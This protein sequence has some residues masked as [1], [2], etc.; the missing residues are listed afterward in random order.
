MNV[1]IPASRA[2]GPRSTPRWVFVLLA[3]LAFVLLF[4]RSMSRFFDLDEHQ[5]VVPP[6]L[7]GQE[8]LLPYR[9]YPYFHM[10]GLVYL[11]APLL[12]WAPDKL[13]AARL[14]SVVCGF[15]TL[16]LLFRVGWR[17]LR[18]LP[19]STRW[20][21][22]GGVVLTFSCSRLFTYTSGWAWNHD[23][24]VL[25]AL[26]AFLVHL[27]G[28]RLARLRCFAAAG[29]LAGLALC[30]RLSFA[31]IVL[32]LALSLLCGRSAL[33]WRQRWLG[34]GLATGTALL[35]LS[36]ALVHLW[37]QPEAFL[38]GNL[39]YARLNTLFYKTVQ[40]PAMNLPQ[41]LLHLGQSFLTDPGNAVL[42]LLAVWLLGWRFFR[43]RAWRSKY[44]NELLLVLGFLP[45][46]LA[47][48]WGPTPTQYQYYY[49]LLPF[50]TLGILYLLALE[51]ADPAVWLRYRRVLAAGAIVVGLTGL[52]RWYRDVI[53]VASPEKWVPVSVDRLG[54]WIRSRCPAE[55]RVLTLDPLVPLEGGVRVYPDYAV[56]RFFAH[57]GKHM[58]AAERQRHHILW[59]EQV[60]ELLTRRPPDAVFCDRR[61]RDM[62]LDFIHYAEGHCFQKLDAPDGTGT[63]WV[64]AQ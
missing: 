61:T 58:S 12:A 24:A 20:L 1:T 13:L 54:E 52:P 19:D 36:P 14:I 56:G 40:S 23:S 60:E 30:I 43:L 28:L 8:G 59:A 21:V 27:R 11:S 38:F 34:L 55:G 49:M 51:S 41:K 53:Q 39:G 7:L 62:S 2:A 42:L 45:A 48:C 6:V 16:V 22:A 35:V 37:A 29:A 10:P 15:A 47:G 17:L 5:F 57:V 32:P 4:A 44:G 3:V 63:L 50:L 64:R 18:H 26:G 25:C 33:T 46:L 31:L 9:D